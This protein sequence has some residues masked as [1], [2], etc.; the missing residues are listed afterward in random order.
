[1]KYKFFYLIIFLLITINSF[2]QSFQR[3]IASSGNVVLKKVFRVGTDYVVTGEISSIGGGYDFYAARITEGGQIKWSRI[4]GRS[5][6]DE[7]LTS[8]IIKD[9]NNIVLAGYTRR[10]AA[11]PQGQIRDMFFV[12]ID[13]D[14]GSFIWSK[15]YG[16]PSLT[17]N[18]APLGMKLVNNNTII[19]S[20]SSYTTNGNLPDVY[21][22]EIKTDGTSIGT[23]I[24]FARQYSANG[25][26]SFAYDIVPTATGYSV[27]ASVFNG[28]YDQVF[29][30]FNPAVVLP[31]SG[32]I[33]TVRWGSGNDDAVQKIIRLSNGNFL[34]F[35]VIRDDGIG[36]LSV[37]EIAPGNPGAPQIVK[38]YKYS[39]GI[40]DLNFER[41][42][43]VIKTKQGGYAL[44]GY[45][46]SSFKDGLIVELDVNLNVVDQLVVGVGG[47]KA[48]FESGFNGGIQNEDD[49]FT[50]AGSSRSFKDDN[51]LEGYLIR[52]NP[53]GSVKAGCK[54]V[55]A[56]RTELGAD[57]RRITTGS[58][59][60]IVIANPTSLFQD[61]DIENS[62]IDVLIN[63]L[64][65]LNISGA[66]EIDVNK[67]LILTVNRRGDAVWSSQ[68]QTGVTKVSSALDKSTYKFSLPG[69]YTI[70]VE[71]GTGCYTSKVITVNQCDKPIVSG[72]PNFCKGLSTTINSDSETGNQ[73]SFNN[74]PITGA[75]GKT[76]L[77][78]QPGNYSVT[79]TTSACTSTSETKLITEILPPIIPITE[80]DKQFCPT[81]Q[82]TLK[83]SN[84]E[85]NTFLYTWFRDNVKISTNFL[86]NIYINKIGEY[87]VMVER[88]ISGCSNRSGV[89][90]IKDCFNCTECIPSFSPL[91]GQKYLLSAWVKESFSGTVPA[92]YKNSGIQLSFNSDTDTLTTMKASG[93][94][95]EGW[96]RIEVPFIVPTGAN[97][98]GINLMNKDAD[99]DVFF[100]DI[101]IHPF[102]SNMK[103]FVYDPS[104]QRLTAELDENNY[105]TRYEYD[106]EGILIRVKKETERGVMTIK[107]TRNNQSKINK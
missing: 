22:L 105:S 29:F 59:T 55:L 63:E 11:E 71:D 74:I 45:T 103:S 23:T 47:R 15:T 66:A 104:T 100:D 35:G 86:P 77:V 84:V 28:G 20:G 94:I 14:D 90:I 12:E 8:S 54:S 95:I 32:T 93:P 44:I 2:G 19:V 10:V 1:M 56:E 64:Q 69:T 70:N 46:E 53:D 27:G 97:A 37:I 67:E 91:Q 85:D 60:E 57:F 51:R 82:T 6:V 89:V 99:G 61:V 52:I 76:L 30:S 42:W 62:P 96:Q 68:Y 92:T 49:G 80:G 4:Y 40:N 26:G 75:T 88:P 83:V 25:N 48:D 72:T 107:E 13:C 87:S 34:V 5:D 21:L 79:V 9:N 38:A 81:N 31:P 50:I 16:S 58:L 36:N 39:I 43:D 101:R 102:K 33:S 65:P 3:L 17:I 7:I 41:M 73:W 106:D 78:N 98:I 24:N 18:E